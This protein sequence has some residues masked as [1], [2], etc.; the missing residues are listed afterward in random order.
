MTFWLNV[1][2]ILNDKQKISKSVMLQGLVLLPDFTLE[3]WQTL[4]L[5]LSYPDKFPTMLE[6]P[7]PEL[8]LSL[9]ILAKQRKSP[10]YFNSV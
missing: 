8:S 3:F 10:I 7:L 2:F 5:Q 9:N 1:R 4:S 6:I